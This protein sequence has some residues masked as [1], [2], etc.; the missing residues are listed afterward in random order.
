MSNTVTQYTTVTFSCSTM[1][2]CYFLHGG[3]LPSSMLPPIHVRTITRGILEIHHNTC[4]AVPSIWIFD[5]WF[6]YPVV[7]FTVRIFKEK[8]QLSNISQLTQSVHKA[9]QA[10]R[11][12]VVFVAVAVATKG[13]CEL[14]GIRQLLQRKKC[15]FYKKFSLN[16]YFCIGYF[17]P[18]SSPP[19]KS[20]LFAML[21][22]WCRPGYVSSFKLTVSQRKSIIV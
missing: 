22:V 18:S 8:A 10:W 19:G 5:R 2:C 15:S 21:F 20:I 4:R 3:R 17:S 14:R 9:D 11:S 12:H 16:L 7:F 6:K 1:A 13:L